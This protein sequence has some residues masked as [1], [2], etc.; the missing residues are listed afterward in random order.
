MIFYEEKN[1]TDILGL[2]I[3]H[4]LFP[5]VDFSW[6]IGL[7]VDSGFLLLS[8]SIFQM[9]I[10]KKNGPLHNVQIGQYGSLWSE[11]QYQ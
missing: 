9:I 10:G 6:T 2:D 3:C 1:L 4:F 11:V 8:I 7:P 5:A